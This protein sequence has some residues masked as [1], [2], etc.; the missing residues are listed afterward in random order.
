MMRST[1][2][3]HLS[4]FSSAAALALMPLAI[5]GCG[6]T[7]SP[8]PEESSAQKEQV[9]GFEL[10]LSRSSFADTEFEHYKLSGGAFFVE[11]G[12]E[13]HGRMIPQKQA[14][15]KPRAGSAEILS[16][17]AA[18]LLSRWR[19]QKPSLETP[20]NNRTPGDPGEYL[21]TIEG[22]NGQT[23]INTSLDMTVND[24]VA[25]GKDLGSFAELV[26]GSAAACGSGTFYGLGR[27]DNPAS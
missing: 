21:L 23:K 13:R 15:E 9:S 12:R 17:T 11:C 22:A 8:V 4:A 6:G 14:L 20:G 27:K 26:R 3:K 18:E 16:T 10:F 25:F 7:A 5:L 19:E 2:S 1:L 24:R